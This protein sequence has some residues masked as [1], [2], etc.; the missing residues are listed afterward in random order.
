VAVIKE[1]TR[2]LPSIVFQLLRHAPENFVVRGELIP[3]GTPV[4]I[5][6]IAQNRDKDIWGP[7]ANEF[8][9][10]RWL[11][12]E[13]RTKYLDTSSMTFGGNGPRMCIGR[14]IALVR[15]IAH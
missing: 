3:A 6:P 13:A 12:D 2:I 7:D 15:Q 5:S 10:E 1:A 14:N 8:R 9:P 4:G 11:Q